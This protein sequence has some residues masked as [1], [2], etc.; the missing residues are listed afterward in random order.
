MSETKL[1]FLHFCDAATVDSLGKINILGIF[2]KVFLSTV[3]GKLAKFAIVLNLTLNNLETLKNKIE[4]KLFDP[5]KEELEIKP[6]I[7][8]NFSIN[9]VTD[10]KKTNEMNLVLDIVDLVFK[11]TGIHTLRIYLNGEEIGNKPLIVEET[12]KS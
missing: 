9:S 12:K 7:I 2:G 3:P 6:P 4:V 1:N 8:L 11:H 10:L 5:S